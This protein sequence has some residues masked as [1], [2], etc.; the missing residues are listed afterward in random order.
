MAAVLDADTIAA[1]LAG[2]KSRGDYDRVI[3]EFLTSGEP[4]W[5]VDLETGPLAGK[6]AKQ[7]KTGLDNARKRTDQAGKLVHEGGADIKVILNDEKAYVINT[8]VAAA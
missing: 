8:A 7:V 5:L 3:T 6:S 2:Q 4:G 1:L